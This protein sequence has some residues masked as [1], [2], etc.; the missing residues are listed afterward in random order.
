MTSMPPKPDRDV[1]LCVDLDGTLL[2]TDLLCECFAWMLRHRW[3]RLFL[4]PCWLIHGKARLKHRLAQNSDLTVELLPLR[5]SLVSFLQQERAG[6]R[7]L[8]LTTGSN[9]KYARKIAG[10]LGI[11]DE[12]M[13]SDENINLTGKTKADLLEQRFGLGGFDYVGNEWKDIAVWDVSRRVIA[14]GASSQLVKHLERSGRSVT[15]IS[16]PECDRSDRVKALRPHQWLKNLL[17]FVPLFTSHRWHERGDLLQTMLGFGV[18]CCLASSAYLLNDLLD[19]EHDRQHQDKVRRPLAAGR[20]PLVEALLLIPVLFLTGF[21]LSSFLGVDF[22]LL[23]LIYYVITILYSS[24][25][26]R[27]VLLDVF[28]LAGLYTLRIL[29]GGAATDIVI[30][31]WLLTFSVFYFVSLGFAKRHAELSRL[32]PEADFMPGRGYLAGDREHLAQAGMSSGYVAVLVFA[33][34][35][36]SPEVRILYSH[37]NILWLCCPILLFW[38]SR[39][40]LLASRGLLTS[41]PVLFAL[42]DRL[43]YLLGFLLM[44]IVFFAR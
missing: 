37:P 36:N 8:Y 20:V 43:S 7:K 9:N 5:K 18:M 10:H 23:A 26:K 40:W 34:Y 11:F 19:L 33:L 41:D 42:R 6:G 4:V 30:S 12:V 25:I 35:I 31:S 2:R 44:L 1:P 38:H 14:A 22:I 13:A 39:L 21:G 27:I 15:V 3:W 17:L 29:L 28:T 16:D 24:W 32:Q